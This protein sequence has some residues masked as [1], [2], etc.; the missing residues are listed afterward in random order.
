MGA[1]ALTVVK[2]GGSLAFSPELPKWL[3]ALAA[4]AGRV[5]V[6]PGGGPFAQAVREGQQKIGYDERAA[7][8]MALLA[9]EQYGTALQSLGKGFAL[10]A[11][12]EDI[13]NLCRRGR[14][15]V[16]APAQMVLA[17]KDMPESWD[18][19][20]D[21]LAAWLAG[22][23]GASRLLLIKSVGARA[24]IAA[25][26]LAARGIV[27]KLFPRFLA[28]SGVAG[29]LVGPSEHGALAAALTAKS[30]LGAPIGLP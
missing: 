8:R 20:S 19:T 16:W 5:V 26:G 29:F 17:E 27:D 22:K 1:D 23:I 30:P 18:V 24:P 14:V 11:S 3:A 9:M 2:L 10:A 12:T 21:S 25:G 15:P 6:V 13:G 28:A 7:H 4:C